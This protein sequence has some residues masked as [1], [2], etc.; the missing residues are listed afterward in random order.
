MPK[1]TPERQLA[2]WLF[3]KYYTSTDVQ[4]K[5]AQA[6]Q[7]FPVRASVADGLAEYFEANPAYKT[8]FELLQYSKFEPPTA[9]YD[10][11]RNE[12]NTTM[13]ALV[14]E[15][16]PD[17]ATSLTALNDLSNSLLAEWMTVVP[18]PAAP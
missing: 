18:T 7:Y 9:G 5:W 4:A 2:T 6:S 12:V 13:A 10:F 11:V 8:A 17:V 3:L 14:A 1:T 15:P 16:Y